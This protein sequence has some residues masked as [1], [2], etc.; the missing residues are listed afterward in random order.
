[1]AAGISPLD[2]VCAVKCVIFWVCM[3]FGDLT[4][5]W[6]GCRLK[7]KKGKKA[8]VQD[9]DDGE[10]PEQHADE[11]QHV[12][13]A[14]HRIGRSKATAKVLPTLHTHLRPK[15]RI[16]RPQA[17]IHLRPKARIPPEAAPRPRLRSAWT[18]FEQSG[19]VS[20]ILD[21]FRLAALV[22]GVSKL[23]QTVTTG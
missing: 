18:S 13:E 5:R 7:P 12:D 1:M 21:K 19:Q 17:R 9:D 22:G 15:A 3:V 16:L 20:K 6:C 8:E 2:V 10:S 14:H 4:T 23:V 11:A